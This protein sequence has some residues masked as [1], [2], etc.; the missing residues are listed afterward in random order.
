MALYEVFDTG[1]RGKRGSGLQSWRRD[2]VIRWRWTNHW[3]PLTASR[4]WTP[5]E[6]R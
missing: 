2:A 6:H 4:L 3:H 1:V 5:A